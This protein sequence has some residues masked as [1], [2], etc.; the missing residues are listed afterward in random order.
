MGGLPSW[1]LEQGA[2]PRERAVTLGLRGLEN[3]ATGPEFRGPE[4]GLGVS[5]D[6]W[7]GRRVTGT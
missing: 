2:R 4:E 6:R 7:V 5:L 1:G 3:S